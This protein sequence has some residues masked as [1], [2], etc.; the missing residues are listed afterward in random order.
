MLIYTLYLQ[1]MKDAIKEYIN[2]FY[3]NLKDHRYVPHSNHY[4]HHAG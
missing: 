2:L 1:A 4:T 3:T